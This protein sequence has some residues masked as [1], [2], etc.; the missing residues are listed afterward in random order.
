MKSVFFAVCV[1]L[2]VV[3]H[4][5]T[6]LA[7]EVQQYRDEAD[8]HYLERDFKK[9]YKIY[10]KL[11]KVGDHYSQDRVS[12]I[13]A[14][15]DGITSNLIEAYAWSVLAAEGGEE[16]ML[17]NS[18]KLLQ[19][20]DDKNQAQNRATKL[21]KKYGKQALKKKEVKLSKKDGLKRSGRCTGSRL[22]CS[23]G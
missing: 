7:N 17:N 10:Y 8:K 21:K 13:Y 9:A 6:V 20:T 1:L 23:R 4:A 3:L 11:A 15:G 12:Q 5:P 14:N 18:Q 22:A 16:V 19:L 2:F